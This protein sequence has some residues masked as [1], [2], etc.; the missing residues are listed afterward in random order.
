MGLKKTPVINT[1]GK[2]FIYPYQD[3]KKFPVYK[4]GDGKKIIL[5][6]E[7]KDVGFRVP[8]P[9]LSGVDDIDK[10]SNITKRG[11]DDQGNP[12]IYTQVDLERRLEYFCDKLIDDWD[13]VEDENGK[14]AEYDPEWLK[15]QFN[16]FPFLYQKFWNHY[17]GFSIEEVAE[18]KKPATGS[19]KTQ[20]PSSKNST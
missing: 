19:S 12:F 4:D 13:G 8:R 9:T 5:P 11:I 3:V 14:P 18:L 20:E 2:V 7:W 17:M 6:E 15:F 10:Y 16:N 1:Q